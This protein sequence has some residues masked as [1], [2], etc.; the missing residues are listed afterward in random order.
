MTAHFQI[1]PLSFQPDHTHIVSV[2]RG[3]RTIQSYILHELNYILKLVKSGVKK[4]RFLGEAY[5]ECV[6]L[7]V[8]L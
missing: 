5:K 7:H 4:K 3:A 8:N 6:Y 1:P 2:C